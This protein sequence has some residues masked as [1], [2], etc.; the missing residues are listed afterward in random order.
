MIDGWRHDGHFA[1][2]KFLGPF[3]C[4]VRIDNGAFTDWSFFLPPGWRDYN[5]ARLEEVCAYQWTSANRLALD[6]SKRVPPQQWITLR[7]ED[8]FDRPVEMFRDVFERLD[9]PFDDALRDRCA[10]LGQRPTS[11][12]KG[13]PAPQK[14]KQS[15]PEAVERVLPM[16][17][18]VM[19]ELGYAMDG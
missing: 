14:W 9:V 19:N 11:I 12:V 18:P 13:A 8:I 2:S 6:A 17:R 16:I 7:Y 10:K 1:L 4:E 5:H 3:P 15:N